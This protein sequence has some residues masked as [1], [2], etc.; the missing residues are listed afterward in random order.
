MK[1][2]ESLFGKKKLKEE[3]G[4]NLFIS[5]I[6]YYRIELNNFES[7]L[8]NLCKRGCSMTV[9]TRE[10]KLNS[11]ENISFYS[12]FML[13]ISSEATWTPMGFKLEIEKRIRRGD[14]NLV[15]RISG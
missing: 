5:A 7:V 4:N 1:K 3:E 2:Y 14:F 15:T 11:G 13:V 8:K 10:K 12:E 6:S 9:L